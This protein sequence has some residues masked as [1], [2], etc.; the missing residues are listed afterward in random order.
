MTLHIYGTSL[1]VGFLFRF[2]QPIAQGLAVP[3]RNDPIVLGNTDEIAEDPNIIIRKSIGLNN[4]DC[5]LIG[6]GDLH[7][8]SKQV[9]GYNA[10]Y[11]PVGEPIEKAGALIQASGMLIYS[12]C[13]VFQM[14]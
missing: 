10:E 6:D 3:L 2:L 4:R 9:V 13:H 11:R 5:H 1:A 12:N 8:S 14:L 7:L